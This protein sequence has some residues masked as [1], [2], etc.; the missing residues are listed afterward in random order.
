MRRDFTALLSL[1]QLSDFCSINRKPFIGVDSYTEEPRVGLRNTNKNFMHI[2]NLFQ[3]GLR[4]EQ[5]N[6][7]LT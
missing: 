6:F 3:Q 2:F 5:K 7:R 4:D 1:V